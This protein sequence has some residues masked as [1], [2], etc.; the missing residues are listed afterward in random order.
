MPRLAKLANFVR[1][2]MWRGDDAGRAANTFLYG[3]KQLHI[4]TYTHAH[5]HI[6]IHIHRPQSNPHAL[7]PQP[8][9][10]HKVSR[11]RKKKKKKRKKNEIKNN[12]LSP[13]SIP[14]APA[15]TTHV[16]ATTALPRPGSSWLGLASASASASALDSLDVC[17]FI[18]VAILAGECN[19]LL[20]FIFSLVFFLFSF[21]LLLLLSFAFFR[22]MLLR[23]AFAGAETVAVAGVG[24]AKLC[25]AAYA[26]TRFPLLHGSWL[27]RAPRLIVLLFCFCVL[28]A[29]ASAAAVAS[30]SASA[31]FCMPL[32]IFSI[33][34]L[35]VIVVPDAASLALLLLQLPRL[36][37]LSM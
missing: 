1:G 30:A 32:H 16:F 21:V 27:W 13:D 29:V 33:L 10:G 12:N 4:F 8:W 22:K 6:R 25:S 9:I 35:N 15:H 36:L 28:V 26:R 3:N 18:C 14:Q 24:S 5:S 20:F 34:R 23:A 2:R 11:S 7:A 19:G 37:S 31:S 17:V